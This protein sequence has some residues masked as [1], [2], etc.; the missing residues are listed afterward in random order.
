MRDLK[1][2]NSLRERASGLPLEILPLDVDKSASV[3]KAV[4]TVIQSAGHI[5]VLINNAG[6]GAFGALEEF[7]DKEILAQYETNVF[8][9]LR[10]TKAVLPA[11]RSQKSGRILHVGSLAG[12]ITFAGI[13]LYCST[14]HAVEAVT[15]SLRLELRPFNV[16]VTVIEPGQMNTSFNANRRMAGVFRQGKSAYQ[17]TLSNILQYGNRHSGQAPGP[18]EVSR[19]ILKALQDS[20]MA[21]R[22][23]AGLDARWFPFLRRFVPDALF[24]QILRVM[25]S[26]FQR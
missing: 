23:A 18:Q 4:S 6:W 22:Y 13:G 8:G 11:M 16:Q 19:T 17:K 24:D 12:R 21:L 7:S 5:D 15:E 2:A 10:M 3:K 25:Y 14:K 9:L 1:K 26:R 20:R